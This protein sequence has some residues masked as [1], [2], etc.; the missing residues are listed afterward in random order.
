MPAA[1]LLLFALAGCTFV[2]PGTTVTN[3][4]EATQEPYAIDHSTVVEAL[5][6]VPEGE[7]MTPERTAEYIERFL[8]QQW[9]LVSVPYPDAMRPNVAPDNPP[10]GTVNDCVTAASGTPE[11]AAIARYVCMARFPSPPSSMLSHEQAAYIYDYW[12]GFVTPCYF[13]NGYDVQ[14]PPPARDTFVAEW[15]LQHWAP[16]PV[17]DGEMVNGEAYDELEALC[18][19]IP[20]ELK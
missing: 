2:A 5:G 16:V 15:P 20:D 3:N 17:S 13:N 12:T 6:A 7:P 4:V 14:S 8:D 18:P 10:N 19:G 11:Q 1:A 9:Q